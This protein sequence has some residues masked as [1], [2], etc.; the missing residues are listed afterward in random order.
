M[1]IHAHPDDE[2]SKGPGTVALYRSQGVHTV[3]VCATGGEEGDILNPEMDRPE[4]RENLGEVRMA[5]LQR[6]TELIGYNEVI[7][8]GYRDSGM[9]DSS[10]NSHPDCFAAAPFEEAVAKLVGHIRRLRPQV[11]ITYPDGRNDYNH[12]DHLA[13]HD[14]SVAAFHA[15]GNPDLYPEAGE[16]FT[17][18]KLYFVSWPRRRMLAMHQAFLDLNLESPFDDERIERM[19]TPE[20]FTTSIHLGSHSLVRRH[21]LRAHATQIDP[22]SPFWFGLPEEVEEKVHPYDDYLLAYSN[23]GEIVEGEDDLFAGIR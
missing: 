15:A 14:T 19:Q 3:L 4:V 11:M 12:P 5:E 6:A 17:P 8:L 21:A 22:N 2:A 20:P 23:V 13:V 7:M 16:A 18:S 1:T 9:A 10:A